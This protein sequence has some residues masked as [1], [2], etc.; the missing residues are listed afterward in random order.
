MVG[1]VVPANI[2]YAPYVQYYINELQK[3][4]VKYEVISWDRLG[5]DESVDHSFNFI[6]SDGNRKRVLL[7]YFGFANFVK[8]IV[9]KRKYDK[10]V[11]FTVAAAFFIRHVLNGKYKNN[12]IFDIRDD[13]PI[14][15]KF[16]S[17]IDKLC[18]NAYQVVTSSEN[19]KKWIPVNP[20][21]GHNADKSM[22]MSHYSDNCTN[23][24]RDQYAIVFA[25]MLIE[26][27]INIELVRQFANSPKVRFGFVGKENEA[28]RE[29]AA[30]CRKEKIENIFYQGVYDKRDIV[31]IY[32]NN[33]DYVNIVR[34]KS[35][36]NKN[37]VP[38]K[39][40]D[41]IISGK[42]VLVLRHNEAI[43]RY[44]EKY[45]LGVII[46]EVEREHILAK[47]AEYETRVLSEDGFAIGRKCFL[48]SV[49]GEIHQFENL[50]REFVE[51]KK[52]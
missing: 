25:G 11:V 3:S 48:D 30:V 39:L 33:A 12:F 44:V 10:L 46:D 45:N 17:A 43:V 24:T 16:S 35:E 49:L 22:I 9:K 29:L 15:R 6:T 1:L 2:K 28:K 32:R 14:A 21:I 38:N 52:V 31:D 23:E 47:I 4:N 42:P 26:G 34:C 8:R 27:E 7:G 40:Y 5:L 20:I 13:S 37:A 51:N 19:F 41:A 36:V 50:V 18:H